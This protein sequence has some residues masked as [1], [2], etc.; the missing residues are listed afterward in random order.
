MVGMIG[1]ACG[2]VCE[3]LRN[4]LERLGRKSE[5][6][7]QHLEHVWRTQLR[8]FGGVYRVLFGGKQMCG[9]Q[10]CQK[11]SC[12]TKTSRTGVS[13]ENA[14]KGRTLQNFVDIRRVFGRNS[15]LVNIQ[16]KHGKPRKNCVP[17]TR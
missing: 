6:E 4:I 3:G 10:T 15:S 7:F 2:S 1:E 16:G 12:K 9:K 11:L 17:I 5:R 14:H 13:T 8:G